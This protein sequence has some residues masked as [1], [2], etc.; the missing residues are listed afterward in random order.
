MSDHDETTVH[1][2]HSQKDLAFTRPSPYGTLVESTY[3]GALS[4]MRRRYTK[5]LSEADVAV[6]GIPFDLAVTNRPGSRFGP[7]AIRQASSMMAW[8]RA[9]GWEFDPF[10]RLAVVDFGDVMFD[11]GRPDQVPEEIAE[12]FRAILGQDVATLMLGGD[13]FST[14]P[15]VKAHAE[16]HGPLSL[17]HFDAHSDT[18][19]DEEGRIDHGTMFFHA[20][21]QGLIDPSRSVQTG[22]R[23]NNDETH[24]FTVLSADWVRKNGVEAT[25]AMIRETVGDNACYLTFD[26]DC[27]DPAFAP[28]TGTPVIGGLQSSE[29]REIL[30]GLAGINLKGMDLVEVAPAYDVG[31][32]TALAG[33]SIAMDLLSIYAHQFPDRT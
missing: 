21:Q 2:E 32:I 33:A 24:G 23:T 13:H 18:W 4:F 25:I 22:I 31:E 17:I 9:W 26:I 5:D 1:D 15:V 27:L 20:A 11:P 10:D 8:D 14:Y 28:G 30:R 3:S 19:R 7:R 6:V 12:Q 16:K 29:A